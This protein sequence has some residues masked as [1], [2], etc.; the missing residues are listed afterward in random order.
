MI[1][2]TILLSNFGERGPCAVPKRDP[3]ET[4]YPER[5]DTD[6][7]QYLL[8]SKSVEQARPVR[9]SRKPSIWTISLTIEHSI[10]TS[11]AKYRVHVM[12]QWN[13]VRT[14]R[15]LAALLNASIQ[16]FSRA[17]MIF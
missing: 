15:A 4:L 11:G 7:L 5:H 9:E 13:T 17:L 12:F 8:L 6:N 1:Q 14:P 10:S 3:A 16:F 2:Y